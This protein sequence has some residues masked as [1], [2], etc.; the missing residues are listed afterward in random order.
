MIATANTIWRCTST[1][2]RKMSRRVPLVRSSGLAWPI[3]RAIDSTITTA[4]SQMM[5]KSMAP[6]ESRL[7]G[8]PVSFIAT[9][10]KA[11]ESGIVIATATAE[12]SDP[13]KRSSTITTIDTPSKSVRPT[14]VSVVSTRSVR[15][16]AMRTFTPLGS[17][18]ALSSRMRV[19][20]PARTSDGFSPRRIS[21]IPSTELSLS[22]PRTGSAKPRMPDGGSAPISTDATSR[23]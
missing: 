3:V 16:Y 14:F 13:R 18:L 9:K 22:V 21:T 10:A 1:P 12:R 4:A 23:T 11:S 17:V 7:A 8:I 15:S 6:R 2:A 20:T 19:L 5:P